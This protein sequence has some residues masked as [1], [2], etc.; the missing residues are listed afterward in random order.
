MLLFLDKTDDIANKNDEFY[1][2]TVKQNLAT[3]NGMSRQLF[4][5]GL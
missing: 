3:I 1:N 5:A 2:P 4:A